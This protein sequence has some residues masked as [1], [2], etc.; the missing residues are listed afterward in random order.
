VSNRIVPTLLPPPPPPVRVPKG[1]GTHARVDE[2]RRDGRHAA[3]D[4]AVL[5]GYAVRAVE[6]RH[7]RRVARCARGGGEERG[8]GGK[9]EGE[10]R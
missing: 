8:G 3:L 4:R 1:E 9:K 2:G 5:D 10:A 6:R 7:A